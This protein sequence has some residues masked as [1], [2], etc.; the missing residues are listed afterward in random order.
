MARLDNRHALYG[1]EP[2]SSVSR[3]PPRRLVVAGAFGAFHPVSLSIAERIHRVRF[4]VGEVIQLL[5][6]D[7]KHTAIRTHPK[8]P[9]VVFQNL[10]NRIVKQPLLDRCETKSPI[11]D[12][13][14]P[15]PVGA[16][17]R[18]SF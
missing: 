1:R 18:R 17:P 5:F 10:E 16:A 2:Q 3:F 9:L 11:S 14:E 8:I 13:R 15:T 7:A 12:S 4:A 6:V